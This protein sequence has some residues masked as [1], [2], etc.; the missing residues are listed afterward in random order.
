MEDL[1]VSIDYYN[2]QLDQKL[3]Q[4]ANAALL[5]SGALNWNNLTE[6]TINATDSDELGYEIDV[7][8]NYDYTEDVKMGLSAGWFK[9][10]KALEGTVSNETNDETALQ[11][12]ATMDVAF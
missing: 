6:T 3:T 12:L 9:P 8:L 2:F 4:S 10:G 5:N 11:V 7:A 1:S